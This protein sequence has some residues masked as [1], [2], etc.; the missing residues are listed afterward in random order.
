[1]KLSLEKKQSFALITILADNGA[2]ANAQNPI[3]I[4]ELATAEFP[5][6]NGQLLVISGMPQNVFA[7]VACHYKNLFGAI[8]GVNSREQVAEVIHSVTK[9]YPVGAKIPLG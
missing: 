2:P 4:A 6:A 5:E 3:A 8:A 7:G 1:M 9:D